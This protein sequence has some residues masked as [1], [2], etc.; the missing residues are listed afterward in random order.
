MP[1][2]GGIKPI[3]RKLCYLRFSRTIAKPCAINSYHDYYIFK[4][5]K[6]AGK[7]RIVFNGLF[8]LYPQRFIT[9][10]Q[11]DREHDDFKNLPKAPLGECGEPWW[12]HQFFVASNSDRE[13]MRTIWTPSYRRSP[14]FPDSP[15]AINGEESNVCRMTRTLWM[16]DV[17]RR[18]WGS[19][20]KPP[21]TPVD[22][23]ISQR[24]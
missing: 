23:D 12:Y 3:G 16:D 5:N 13:H 1:F 17:M 4:S 20:W 6:F 15:P 24:D 10:W 22:I 21:R 9:V 19:D 2:T 18:R 7:H 8:M 14:E 11:Y